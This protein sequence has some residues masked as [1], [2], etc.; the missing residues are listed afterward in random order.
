[1]G[2]IGIANGETHVLTYYKAEMAL[3]EG[4]SPLYKR[5]GFI[6]LL[7]A[8]NGGVCTSIHAKDHYH[9]MG[10]WHA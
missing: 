3:P 9:H 2:R 1:M 8:P 6:H 7:M 10:L 5:S 4:T